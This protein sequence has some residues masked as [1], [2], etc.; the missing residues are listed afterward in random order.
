MAQEKD[1]V[2]AT[3]LKARKRRSMSRSMSRNHAIYDVALRLV[4]A[5]EN[6]YNSKLYTFALL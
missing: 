2:K 6:C 4:Q 3:F 5:W 1:G